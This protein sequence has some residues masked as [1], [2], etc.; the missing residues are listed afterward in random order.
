MNT[1][2]YTVK[3]SVPHW[4]YVLILDGEIIIPLKETTI[5]EAQYRAKVIV[6]GKQRNDKN[7]VYTVE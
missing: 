1:A 2:Y 6:G 7:Y 3:F 5:R 4:D